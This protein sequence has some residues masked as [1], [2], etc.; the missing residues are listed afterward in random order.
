MRVETREYNG[1]YYYV[2]ND[3]NE[4]YPSSLEVDESMIISRI[5]NFVSA[6]EKHL[7][8]PQIITICRSRYSG[9]TAKSQWNFI[10]TKLV[11]KLVETYE[12]DFHNSI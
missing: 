11:E 9:Y 3:Y 4:I 7:I 10:E 1:K 6:L 8:M 12:C 2:I 5:D